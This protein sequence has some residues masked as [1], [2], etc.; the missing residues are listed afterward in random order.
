[1]KLR[2]FDFEHIL[3]YQK[4]LFLDLDIL[5]N[6]NSVNKVFEETLDPN[7]IYVRSEGSLAEFSVEYWSTVGYSPMQIKIFAEKGIRPFNSGTFLFLVGPLM[8]FHFENILHDVS[9]TNSRFWTEQTYMNNYFCRLYRTNYLL[10][11]YVA[12]VIH[13]QENLKQQLPI[14]HFYTNIGDPDI[15]FTRMQKHFTKFIAI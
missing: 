2:I 5:V 1:M 9:T 11:K 12:F 14:L 8:R 3:N 6:S 15:K 4:V 10:D 7:F 13:Q